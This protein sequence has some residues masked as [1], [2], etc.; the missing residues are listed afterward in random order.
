MMD[1]LTHPLGS[2]PNNAGSAESSIGSSPHVRWGFVRPNFGFFAWLVLGFCFPWT[3]LH[4]QKPCI[5]MEREEWIAILRAI[6]NDRV[7]VCS[8][9]EMPP[10]QLLRGIAGTDSCQPIVLICDPQLHEPAICIWRSRLA[11]QGVVCHFAPRPSRLPLSLRHQQFLDVFRKALA[12]FPSLDMRSLDTEIQRWLY[13][14]HALPGGP[15]PASL[16]FA[17][18]PSNSSLR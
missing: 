15:L 12:A 3:P 14:H 17:E 7:E 13:Q 8:L 6:V 11:S 1:S 2:L 9:A 4:A 16:R 5:V 10:S 18:L